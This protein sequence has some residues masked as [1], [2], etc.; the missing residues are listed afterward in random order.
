MSISYTYTSLTAII[1]SYAEDSDVDFVDN[2]PDMIAKAE[3][4]ILR[5]LDLEM[6]EQWI[7]VTI[8]GSDRLV[9]KP[10]DAIEINDVWLRT[11]SGQ[12]WTE[13]PRRSFE[14]CLAFAPIES[15]ES[16]PLYYSEYD[17]DSIYVVPTPDQSYT[18]GNA[19]VRATIRP[20][21]LSADNENTWLGDNVADMLFQACMIEAWDFLKNPSK[22]QAAAVAYQSL[23]PSIAIEIEEIVRKVY[24]GLN[25][26]KQG[27]DD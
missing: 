13:L 2:I 3:T 22:V 27:A 14:Y 17:E 6:F 15:E 7:E 5:D 9:T 20:T 10:A 21:A 25:K 19:R 12:K 23:V 24:K 8:S 11:P 26:S 16:Q 4:R 18:S 1:Q